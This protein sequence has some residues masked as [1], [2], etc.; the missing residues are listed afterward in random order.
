MNEFSPPQTPT[1]AFPF[2]E[3]YFASVVGSLRDSSVKDLKWRALAG[4]ASDRKY[5]RLSYQM[6]SSNQSET[7]VVM[8]L[9]EPQAGLETDFTRILKFLRG[10]GLPAPELFH[11]DPEKGLLLLEDCGEVTL[12]E[13]IRKRPQRLREYYLEAVELLADMQDRATREIR[14]DCPAYPLRFD[15]EKLMGEFDFMLKHYVEK[16]KGRALSAG[17]KN[18]IRRGFRPLCETLAAQPVVFTH[19]DYH[20]RNLMVHKGRLVLLD[21]QDA[22]MGPC[23][24]DLASLLKDSYVA[25]ED[26]FRNE[27]IEHFMDCKDRLEGTQ[28]NREAFK[29]ILDWMGIQRNLKA[30]GTFAFQSVER[31]NDRYL[32]YVP[33]TLDYVRGALQDNSE[34]APL[35]EILLQYLPELSRET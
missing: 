11:Y 15:V 8:R 33:R 25:L 10:L 34:L 5:Y 19:R 12:E 32:Q 29:K 26:G 35:R 21:F 14:P 22:R 24:Y 17:A 1:E 20:S 23:H 6:S 30:V 18:Q 9:K 4:D 16:L 7:A 28:G 31:G 3:K 27:M 13:Q 2:D